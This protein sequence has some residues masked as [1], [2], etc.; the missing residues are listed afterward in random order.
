MPRPRE[1][2]P[3]ESG[4]KLDLNRLVRHEVFRSATVPCAS[5][6]WTRSADVTASGLLI[7]HLSARR[8]S[9]RLHLGEVEQSIELVGAARHFGGVQWYFLCPV[10]GRRASILWMPP[11][12]SCFA[13][14]QA[15]GREVAYASQFITAP[16]RALSRAHDIRRRLGDEE[17]TRVFDAPPPSK[18]RGMHRYTY[19]ALL[20]R[21]ESYERKCDFYVEKRIARHDKRIARHNGV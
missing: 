3:L 1:R 13:S 8:G 11:G 5:I 17:Y 12:K 6:K 20:E 9:M 16:F 19:E 18:P 2:I 15:W 4:L 14:R 21:L 7:W 10:L